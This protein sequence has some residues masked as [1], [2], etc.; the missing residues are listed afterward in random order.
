[1]R[2]STQ[3]EAGSS[4]LTRT[5]ILKEHEKHFGLIEVNLEKFRLCLS[6][7]IKISGSVL[8][9]DEDG[10]RT[11]EQ[12]A[13]WFW[14]YGRNFDHGLEAVWDELR[15]NATWLSSVSDDVIAA[16]GKIVSLDA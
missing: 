6:D 11:L 13:G 12:L 5:K 4:K 3:R 1:M 7:R 8:N 9:V 14:L 10:R 2:M 15:D 16:I